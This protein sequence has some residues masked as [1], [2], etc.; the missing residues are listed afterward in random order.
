MGPMPPQEPYTLGFL[1]PPY[2]KRL[3]EPCLLS[4]RDGG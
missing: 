2:G 3:A 4:L 1:D